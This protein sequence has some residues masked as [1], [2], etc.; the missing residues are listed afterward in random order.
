MEAPDSH[1]RAASRTGETGQLRL[2]SRA[3]T[4]EIG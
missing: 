1:D 2:G 3:E 4:E